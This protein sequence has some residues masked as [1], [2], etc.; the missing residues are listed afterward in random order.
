MDQL[1]RLNKMMK[2]LDDISWETEVWDFNGE[3]FL[4]PYKEED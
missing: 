4:G 2:Y 3:R 1:P